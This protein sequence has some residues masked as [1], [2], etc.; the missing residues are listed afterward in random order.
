M[1]KHEIKCEDCGAPRMT[2]MP[3]TKFC[4]TCRL[5]K[6]LSFLRDSTGKCVAC[7]KRHAL[8]ERKAFLCQSCQAAAGNCRTGDCG[9]CGT[10][11]TALVWQDVAVCVQCM[12]DPKQRGKIMAGLIKKIAHN[13]T[14]YGTVTESL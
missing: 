8:T 9:V 1:A 5:F 12:D 4:T 7:G 2:V 11:A 3:N 10:E 13:R 14:E 6:N